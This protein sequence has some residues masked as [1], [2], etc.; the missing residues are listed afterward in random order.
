MATQPI[1]PV[2]VD[3]AFILR[4]LRE[5]EKQLGKER[6]MPQAFPEHWPGGPSVDMGDFQLARLIRARMG[7]EHLA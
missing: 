7:R 3:R 1:P 6:P 4:R 5:L 2:E